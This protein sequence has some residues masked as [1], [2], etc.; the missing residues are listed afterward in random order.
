LVE[1]SERVYF[2]QLMATSDSVE[3]LNAFL[4]KREAVWAHR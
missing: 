3:G 2:E 1:P 4:E